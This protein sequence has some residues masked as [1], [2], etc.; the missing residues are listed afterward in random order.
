MYMIL[1][2]RKY[3]RIKKPYITRYKVIP[4]DYKLTKD[5]DGVAV[6][7]LSAGGIFIYSRTKLEVGTIVDLRIGF[8]SLLPSQICVGR[9]VR[10]KKHLGTFLFSI[11]IAFTEI[12]ERIKEVINDT[13]L[14]VN[15]DIQFPSNIFS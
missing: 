3:L 10:V 7:N 11:A 4:D 12:D 5:W 8:L 1:E 13:A 2:R 14:S 6:V 15:P 9:V